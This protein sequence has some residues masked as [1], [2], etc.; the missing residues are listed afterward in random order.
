M[1]SDAVAA[2]SLFAAIAGNQGINVP[3]ATESLRVSF[4]PDTATAKP[5]QARH[6]GPGLPNPSSDQAR[7][8]IA[9]LSL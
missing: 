3:A 2:V 6:R 4:I 9:C 5:D 7:I 8:S 1:S